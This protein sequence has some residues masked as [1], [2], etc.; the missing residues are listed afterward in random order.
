MV[1]R[2][3]CGNGNATR[4]SCVDGG[5]KWLSFE[6]LA[7]SIGQKLTTY[8]GRSG[9]TIAETAMVRSFGVR[10]SVIGDNGQKIARSLKNY[11]GDNLG[12]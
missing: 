8:G 12:Y 4:R 9:H 6:P 5:D 1:I 11:L 2:L 7:D 10:C 3:P